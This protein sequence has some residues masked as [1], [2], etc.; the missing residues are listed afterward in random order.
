MKV[1]PMIHLPGKKCNLGAVVSGA[2]LNHITDGDLSTLRDA[3]WRHK[4]VVIKGQESFTP[5]NNWRLL[6]SLDPEAAV[7]SL[8]EYAQ[9]FHPT[10]EPIIAN[11]KRVSIPGA[12][13]IH[14]MGKGYQG[15]DHW[16]VK[17]LDIGEMYAFDYYATPLS[18]DDFENGVS[19]FQAWHM[20]GPCY[21]CEPPMYTSFHLLKLPDSSRE[22]CVEWADGSGLTMTTKPGRTAFW[23]SSQL[24]DL[25]SPEEK[26][27]ADHSWFEYMYYPFE[28][29]KA[30]RGNA[31]GVGLANEGRETPMDEMEK[32]PRRPEWQKKYPMVLVNHVT[33]EKSF[34]VQAN[35]VHKL[36][37]RDGPD[38][39]PTVITDLAE[40]RN[41][42][43]NI[44]S[45]IV[46]PEYIYMGPEEEGDLL[47]WLNWGVM[48]SRVD[49][50]VRYGVRTAH[51][52]WLPGSKAPVGPVP[53]PANAS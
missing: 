39:T 4:V 20:D 35:C 24:Y 40:I 6:Q 7:P 49:Y 50:P 12:G 34:Q 30:C 27:M 16:G 44:Q 51:G 21:K 1:E 13:L 52:G 48:H 32:I 2:D 3:I 22:Q 41:F 33:G 18:E 31:N 10:A 46:R 47:L 9:F 37:L 5:Q 26:R 11:L 36:F 8:E 29:I 19:R 28:W 14:V 17:E 43:S 53:I 45:R 23:S 15:K 38:E 25:L 42:L